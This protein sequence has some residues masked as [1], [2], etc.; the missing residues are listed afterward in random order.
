MIRSSRSVDQGK[1]GNQLSIHLSHLCQE[2]I[3]IEQALQSVGINKKDASKIGQELLRVYRQGFTERLSSDPRRNEIRQTLL[4]IKR[5]GIKLEVLS[6]ERK[7]AL[8]SGLTC[9]GHNQSFLT[10]Y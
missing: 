8:N 10:R 4:Y 3:I 6:N 7:D 5:K 9:Y 1:Q 2:E